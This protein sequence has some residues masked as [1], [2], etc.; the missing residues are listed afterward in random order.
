MK[1]KETESD[2][3]ANLIDPALTQCGWGKDLSRIHREHRI[4]DG[5]ISSENLNECAK[6]I[7]AESSVKTK[8]GYMVD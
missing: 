7:Q 3:R 4:T 1:F 8:W 2:T 6:L 5:R